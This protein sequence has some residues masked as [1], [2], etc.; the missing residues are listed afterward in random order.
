MR[1]LLE[2]R[3]AV[4]ST[5]PH[6]PLD[7]GGSAAWPTGLARLGGGAGTLGPYSCHRPLTRLGL[8]PIHPLPEGER[9]KRRPPTRSSP[10]RGEGAR[11]VDEGDA[12]T[13]TEPAKPKNLSPPP[14]PSYILPS[15][16][17]GCAVATNNRWGDRMEKGSPF[18]RSR[19]WTEPGSLPGHHV[20]PFRLH[21]TAAATSPAGRRRSSPSWTASGRYAADPAR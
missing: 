1:A 21:R 2:W 6:L 8:R 17:T 13:G 12:P 14:R 10:P 18:F 20:G 3:G 9:N 4:P 5:G 7:G 16:P 11:R 19:V 15:L